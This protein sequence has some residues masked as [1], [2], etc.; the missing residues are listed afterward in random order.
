MRLPAASVQRTAWLFT[1]EHLS[2]TITVD[3]QCRDELLLIVC[4]PGVA[5]ATYDFR[6]MDALIAFAEAEERRLLD[7]GF[8]LQAVAERRSGADRREARRPGNPDRRRRS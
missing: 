8:Q 1:R 5:T 6:S 3:D 2:V 7:S 4:G